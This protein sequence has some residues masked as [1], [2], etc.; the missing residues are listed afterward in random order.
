MNETPKP[1]DAA[2][3]DAPHPDDDI[4]DFAWGGDGTSEHEP[5]R[6]D[7]EATLVLTD[8]SYPAP[9]DRFLEFGDPGRVPLEDRSLYE[10]LGLTQS[11][12]PHLIRMTR[13][14]RLNTAPGTSRMV[15]APTHAL[16]A[17]SLLDIH[18]HIDDVIPL[19]NL[20]TDWTGEES[21]RIISGAGG[22]AL[23]SLQRCM[24]DDT[25]W[26]YARERAMR[27]I[28]YI[29]QQSPELRS[30]AIDI[31]DSFLADWS[32]HSP[33]I[34]GFATGT[35]LDLKS[36]ESL[37]TIRAAF[38]QNAVDE[39]I[40]GDWSEVLEELEQTPDPNDPLIEQSRIHTQQTRA[41][42]FPWAT[43][44]ALVPFVPP[45]SSTSSKKK[46]SSQKN[47]R[48]MASASRK[49]NRKKKK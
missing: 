12:V 31:L 14:R 23:P 19:F 28:G 29:G 18:E 46:S 10:P 4:E 2:F 49:T 47:K 24:E 15:W 8:E 5:I 39:T 26:S 32:K 37:P 40:T 45:A 43:L 9:L 16:R 1:H 11:H 17:L 42:Q 13:D 21:P 44:P 35:L 33:M 22:A 38:E 41:V 30:Q 25:R 6:A 20:D 3:V 27:T 48:K 36:V 34:N 7:I